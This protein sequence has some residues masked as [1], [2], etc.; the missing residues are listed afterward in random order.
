MLQL[1]HFEKVETDAWLSP[2][3]DADIHANRI[4]RRTVGFNLKF[5]ALNNVISR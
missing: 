1:L 5:I 3:D 4:G 2:Y